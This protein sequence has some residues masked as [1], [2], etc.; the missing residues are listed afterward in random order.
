[1]LSLQQVRL[2]S[3]IVELLY[4]LRVSFNRGEGTMRSYMTRKMSDFTLYDSD[5]TPYERKF[6]KKSSHDRL[7]TISTRKFNIYLENIFPQNAQSLW[8]LVEFLK[9][10]REQ[11]NHYSFNLHFGKSSFHTII[12]RDV[13]LIY[14]LTLVCCFETQIEILQTIAR[15]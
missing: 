2:L 14:A 1:M 7:E 6:H 13:S 5:F 15:L 4:L 10:S 11:I 3:F 12:F 8:F 9:N